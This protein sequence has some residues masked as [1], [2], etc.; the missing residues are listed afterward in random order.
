LFSSDGV[1]HDGEAAVA[2][3]DRKRRRDRNTAYAVTTAVPDDA[4]TGVTHEVARRTARAVLAD[5]LAGAEQERSA[6]AERDQDD[7]VARSVATHGEQLI[8]MVTAKA[9]TGRTAAQLD[10]LAADDALGSVER[11]LRR[12]ELVGHD[13]ARALAA[14]VTVSAA[15]PPP[16]G[17]SR[18]STPPHR[19]ATQ[20]GPAGPNP[21]ESNSTASN[22]AASSCP[23]P[24]P[25]AEQ[26]QP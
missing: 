24:E 7:L 9:V 14:A 4:P 26:Q 19:P 2:K 6:A 5:L 10:Q 13:P 17:R 25:P 20:S 12:A 3:T 22:D 8:E 23:C 18:C 1:N 16:G 21:P 11:L 15:R